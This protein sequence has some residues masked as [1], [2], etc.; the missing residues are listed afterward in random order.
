MK[1]KTRLIITLSVFFIAISLTQCSDECKVTNTYIYFEPVYSTSAEIKA[2]VELQPPHTLTDLGKIY[3]KDGYLFINEIGKG[4]H[5]IDNRNPASPQQLSFLNIP[6]NYDLAAYGDILYADSYTDLVAFS[7]SDISNIKEVD[8]IEGLFNNT[9]VLGMMMTSVRGTITDWRQVENVTVYERECNQQYWG[10][11]L[12]ADGIALSSASANSFSSRKE[13]VAPTS[14]SSGAGKGGSMARFT[15]SGNHLY[16]MDG[17][18]L[19]IVSISSPGKPVE[20]KEI[21]IAWDIETIFPYNS[22]LFFGTQSGMLIYDIQDAENPS[23]VSTYSHI[24]SCDPVVVEGNYAYVTL[25]NG[26]TCG[27]F[28]NQLEVIDITNLKSPVL[29]KTCPMTNPFGLGID[30]GTLFV[31]DGSSGLRVFDATDVNQVCNKTLAHYNN[32]QALDIIPFQNVAMMITNDGLYQ[33][34]YSDPTKI[35]LL[36]T[37]VLQQ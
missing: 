16:A 15:I 28:T 36:S 34:D 7:I 31:C 30:N 13:M 32:I 1:T 33:Y 6:G 35:K 29:T 11:M 20:K 4:I 23:L 18:K 19:D 12:Y 17:G 10:G 25:R 9:M 37:L 14:P 2:A 3:F 26:S 21:N 5:I 8:R 22:N 27:G 24:R